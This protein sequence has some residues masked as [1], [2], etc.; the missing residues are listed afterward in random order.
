MFI[1]VIEFLVLS[2]VP[3]VERKIFISYKR[4]NKAEVMPLV[5]TIERLTG[6]SCWLD[7][8]GIESDKQFVDVIIKAINAAQVFVLMYSQDHVHVTDVTNEWTIKELEYAIQKQ[9]RIV[10]INVDGS[11]LSDYF[12]FL[13]G[14]RQQVDGRSEDA[15]ARLCKELKEWIS[16]SSEVHK[17]APDSEEEDTPAGGEWYRQYILAK[18][19]KGSVHSAIIK[20]IDATGLIVDLEEG[21]QGFIPIR[22]LRKK[23]LLIDASEFALGK[24]I[25]VRV[26]QVD[27]ENMFV[28]LTV[29]THVREI[30]KA[31][32]PGYIPLKVLSDAISEMAN[33]LEEDD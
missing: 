5:T 16:S 25:D 7:V 10:F 32:I 14:S 31:M 6:E 3:M 4:A 28:K 1:F 30:A 19:S 12:L 27:E 20:N 18:Y 29:A 24:Q 33:K 22:E 2:Q 9:K 8:T 26:L 11:P 13:F 21:V 23:S 17:P 15:V